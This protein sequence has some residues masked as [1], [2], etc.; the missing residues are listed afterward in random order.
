MESNRKRKQDTYDD[1]A[2]LRDCKRDSYCETTHISWNNESYKEY[3]ERKHERH[4]SFT[5]LI[6]GNTSTHHLSNLCV[7]NRRAERSLVQHFVLADRHGDDCRLQLGTGH[8]EKRKTIFSI[9]HGIM[10]TN[11][12]NEMDIVR[13]KSLS[14][15][16][17]IL[18]VLSSVLSIAM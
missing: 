7:V 12:I 14:H 1:W 2:F 17:L 9:V 8:A 15:P 13:V 11:N 16:H 6:V 10:I 3:S 18:I 4:G 5:H